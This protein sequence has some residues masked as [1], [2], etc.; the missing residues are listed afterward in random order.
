MA[1]LWAAEDRADFLEAILGSLNDTP[2][3]V[4]DRDGLILSS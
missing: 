3:V 2:V 4:L 1:E